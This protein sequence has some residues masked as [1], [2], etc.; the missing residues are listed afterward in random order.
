MQKPFENWMR[1]SGS[2]LHVSIARLKKW[3]NNFLYLARVDQSEPRYTFKFT[4]L[5]I[6]MYSLIRNV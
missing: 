3:P 4:N 5:Q 6:N 2:K 1:V